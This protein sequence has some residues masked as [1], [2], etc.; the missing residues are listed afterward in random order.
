MAE[1]S[2]TVDVD[3]N[4]ANT[5]IAKDIRR[6]AMNLLARREHSYQELLTKLSR[7]FE[8]NDLIAEQLTKLRHENL[9]SDMR[10][11]ESFTH[12]RS[13]SGKGPVR[14]AAELQERG[15]NKMLI[16]TYLNDC[17]DGWVQIARDVRRKRFGASLPNTPYEQAKQKRFLLY[18]GFTFEHLNRIF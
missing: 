15:I 18:R 3:V 14:I 1:D 5:G 6:A 4:T 10:F 13:E 8:C 11:A 17:D 12:Y 16:N 2:V 7:R 9:Q